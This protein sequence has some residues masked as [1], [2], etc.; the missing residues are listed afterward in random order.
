MSPLL[1]INKNKKE[2][3]YLSV[4][5]LRFIVRKLY[6]SFKFIKGGNVMGKILAIN[7]GSSSLKFQL[8]EMPEETVLA[9]GLID[10]I[11][12]KKSVFMIET[13][14]VEE[15]ITRDMENHQE[16]VE[17][18][19]EQLLQTCAI[20]SYDEIESVGHRVVH[21]GEYFSDSVLI[22]DEVIAKI[23]EVSELAPLHNPPNLTGIHA[24]KEN[25]PNV[26]MVAVFDTAFHQTMPESSYIYSLPYEYY[27]KYG[28][29]KYGFHG[30]SHKYVAE[31]AAIMLNKP[32]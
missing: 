7:A 23:E 2:A 6:K 21:G 20:K 13:D 12:F 5:F 28:I 19:L 17:L 31:R 29:R 9:K 16:A 22:D 25:L 8:F 32:L 14:S 15:K 10:R 1:H 3:L 26:P 11:G 24:Y 30:T 4:V 27:E 18:L